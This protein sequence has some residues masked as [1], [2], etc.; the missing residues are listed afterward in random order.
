MVVSTNKDAHDHND[1]DSV[2]LHVREVRFDWT[3]LPMRWIPREAFA[4]HLLNVLHILLPEG[5]RFFVKIF[6][7]ALPL[8]RDDRLRAD[9][10]GFIGQEQM[11][12][13]AHQGVQDHFAARGLDTSGY[14]REVEYLCTVM[15]G[16]R[17]LRGSKKDE[18]LVERLGIVAGIEHVTAFLGT[19]VLTA[20][21]L[22]TVGADPRMLDLLRWHG[23]EEVEHRAVA[24][25]VFTHLD[26]RYLR[27]ARTYAI[28]AFGLCWLWG[29]G[30]RY[31]MAH[32]PSLVPRQKARFRDLLRTG[33][34]GLTPTYGDIVTC[35]WRYFQPSYHPSQ[36]G[37]TNQAVRYLASSPAALAADQRAS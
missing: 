36:Q 4:S 30:V 1:V 34:R 22:D 28:A 20:S 5:E 21:N 18:W 14:V 37:S 8:I 26:G 16:D 10:L 17:G 11:H 27:R 15:L 24:Y 9:V 35:G 6:A 12:A 2:A 33:R 23:A 7:E 32:D 31:L 29:R 25:D 13:N 19:W 3:G